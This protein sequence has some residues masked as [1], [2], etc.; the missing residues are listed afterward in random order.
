MFGNPDD[1]IDHLQLLW[2]LYDPRSL[3]Y[4]VALCRQQQIE[5][6]VR[7]AGNA[8][9]DGGL[10]GFAVFVDPQRIDDIWIVLREAGVV[11]R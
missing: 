9:L 7:E 6:Q 11:L 4:L 1:P 10:S 8:G 3:A 2:T 5:H